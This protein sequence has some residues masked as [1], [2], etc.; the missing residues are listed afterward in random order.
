M[1]VLPPPGPRE[2]SVRGHRGVP[3]TADVCVYAW[4][5]SREECLA[6]AVRALVSGFA[7]VP[8]RTLTT[9]RVCLV[10]ARD[11]EH[12]LAAVLEE[13]IYLLDVHQELAIDASVRPVAGGATVQFAV[14]DAACAE[15]IG[16][17]P[18]AVALHGLRM[19]HRDGTWSCQASLDV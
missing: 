1:T 10:T 9:T 5:E 2:Q 16:A 6:E 11:D 19:D 14:V 17:V 7:R 15:Q 3:H 13:V 12:L 18:K 4:A 8:S